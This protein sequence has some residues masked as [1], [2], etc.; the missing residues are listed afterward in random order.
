MTTGKRL[1][2]RINGRR[3]I[4]ASEREKR[5]LLAATS[6][7]ETAPSVPS[8]TAEGTYK[9]TVSIV[10]QGHAIVL[11]S[12]S[13]AEGKWKIGYRVLL[14]D[15][16]ADGAAGVDTLH[17][18]GVSDRTAAS[19]DDGDLAGFSRSRRAGSRR[20][21]LGALGRFARVRL[22]QSA[23]NTLLVDR[24]V[25]DD[26]LNALVNTWEVRYRRSEKID[27]PADRKDTFGS[28]D[29]EGDTFIEATTELTPVGVDKGWFTVVLTP[30]ALPGSE[31]W[32]IFR[33]QRDLAR[34]ELLFIRSNVRRPVR[35]HRRQ[36]D[37]RRD[38]ADRD[39]RLWHQAEGNG[40]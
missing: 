15:E 16:E 28:T 39:S 18:A 17:R 26:L 14:P 8:P 37:C 19:R 5:A 22:R 2:Q 34:D 11:S 23:K 10:H 3:S 13:S 4:A 1:P 9:D 27:I 7:R 40:V 6:A 31:R 25:Y 32:R 29:M 38:E 21:L 33:V 35:S 30:A 12:R 36:Q 24:F 20:T